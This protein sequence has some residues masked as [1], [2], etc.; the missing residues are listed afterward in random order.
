MHA[1]DCAAQNA[2]ARFSPSSAI[3]PSPVVVV[4]GGSAGESAAKAVPIFGTAGASVAEDGARTTT[5]PVPEVAR[6]A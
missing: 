2:D 4:S 6:A 1:S 3:G 5:A